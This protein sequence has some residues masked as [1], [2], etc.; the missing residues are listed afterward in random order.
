MKQITIDDMIKCVEREIGMRQRVYPR[1]VESKK[2]SQEKADYEIK[3]MEY[4]LYQLKI[5]K[6]TTKSMD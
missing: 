3:C 4:V 1:W 5:A 2:M 6:P